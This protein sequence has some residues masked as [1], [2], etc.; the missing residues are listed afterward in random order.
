MKLKPIVLSALI[1]LTAFVL[2]SCT[3]NVRAKSF[4]GTTTVDLPAGT[5]LVNVTWKEAELWYLTRPRTEGEKP[6]SYTFQE[7]S[8]FGLV[9]GKVIFKEQ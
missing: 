8:G 9:E 7:K 2:P 6:I 5:S 3:D 1:A 4:G